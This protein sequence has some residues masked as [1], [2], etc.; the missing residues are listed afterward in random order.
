MQNQ[1]ANPFL[2]F[3]SSKYLATELFDVALNENDF[4]EKAMRIW[5]SMGNVAL[6]LHEYEVTIDNT[7]TVIMPCNMERI[8]AVT[9]FSYQ[10][11]GNDDLIFIHDASNAKLYAGQHYADALVSGI[12]AHNITKQQVYPKGQYLHYELLGKKGSYKL[13]FSEDM[14]GQPIYILYRAIIVGDDGLPL[15]TPKEQEAIAYRVAYEF[16]QKNAFKGDQLAINLLP[17]IRQDSDI[18]M[19]AAKIPEYV[20]QNSWDQILR[21]MVR[22]DRKQYG[23]SYKPIT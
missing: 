12:T 16:T 2:G 1:E 4:V 22:H 23:Y 21:A 14:V 11:Y 13:H 7:C 20:S 19:A 18:K 3:L 10:D 5:R 15:I 8:E 6:A 17:I 9:G